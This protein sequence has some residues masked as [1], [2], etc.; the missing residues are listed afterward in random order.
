MQYKLDWIKGSIT[1]AGVF[2]K[3]PNM[4]RKGSQQELDRI[5]GERA[6]NKAAAA[7]RFL[8]KKPASDAPPQAEPPKN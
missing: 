4:K 7:A 6:R 5:M 8:Q 2:G 1:M 3:D